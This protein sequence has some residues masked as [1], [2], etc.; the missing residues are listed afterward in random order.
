M[1][2]RTTSRG[3]HN[4]RSIVAVVLPIIA[5]LGTSGLMFSATLA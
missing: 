2:S 5:A 1:S 4:M 3:A